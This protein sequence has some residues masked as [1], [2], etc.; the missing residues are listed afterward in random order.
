[1]A[2]V[3]IRW[4]RSSPY[5][6]NYALKDR[7][8]NDATFAHDCSPETAIA[9][10]AAV[11]AEH[12]QEGG[13]H[14]LHVMQSFSP[15]DSNLRSPEQL[16]ALGQ[17]LALKVFPGHQFVIRTH[18]DTEKT[19]NHIIVNTVHSGTGKKIENKRAL[20]FRLQDESD[21]LCREGG[22]SV[23]NREAKVRSAKLPYK[24]QHMIR[25]GKNSYLL[26]LSQKADVARSIAT[27][28]DEYR[29]TLH[30]FG[31]RVL[32]EEK[33]I[34]Y[35]YPG[36]ERGKRGSKL[37][38]VYDKPGLAEA[39]ETNQEKFA[40][41][42]ELKA[43]FQ[44]QAEQIA[45]N[46]MP[47]HPSGVSHFQNLWSGEDAP[48]RVPQTTK[49]QRRDSNA[50]F[51]SDQELA[52]LFVPAE[53]IRRARGNSLLAYCERNKIALTKNDKGETVL[54]GR[55]FVVVS[56]FEFQNTKNGTRGSIIDLVAAHKNMT[57]LQAA[58]HLNGNSRLLLLERTAGE[59][60][61]KFR[62]FYV[63]N[64]RKSS[65]AKV[66]NTLRAFARER[67]RSQ[68]SHKEHS[69][70]EIG[71]MG[72]KGGVWLFFEDEPKPDRLLMQ[73]ESA[74]FAHAHLNKA[75]GMP[76]MS[77]RTERAIDLFLVQNPSVKTIHFVTPAS[78]DRRSADLLF[79]DILRRK[80]Q[81][82]GIDLVAVHDEKSLQR[83]FS[84]E[85]RASEIS[86]GK[87]GPDIGF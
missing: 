19:H 16:N 23:I 1:M 17:A 4:G 33:N 3:S 46:G 40:H 27:N 55:E 58:A 63:P 24:A 34:S 68:P 11:R 81:S 69:E 65:A 60:A 67:G 45:K 26:D 84:I 18:T 49:I 57:L 13:N 15:T 5:H 74:L 82:L 21:T 52:R 72:Q 85:P 39:F 59:I 62:S 71:R 9:D 78:P 51:H 64:L 79:G 29:D 6:L 80:Y 87:G 53:E 83:S 20:I 70:F 28:F 7:A 41:R 86:R 56:E 48:W 77:H 75:N 61:P 35:F 36:R 50:A 37:G 32:I 42:P 73:H 14:V 31:I 38:H 47:K 10:F 44:S 8:P 12:N 22:L 54:R 25:A 30:A 66:A 2:Y 43:L 76:T